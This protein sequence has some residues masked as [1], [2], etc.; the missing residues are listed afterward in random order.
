VGAQ[1]GAGGEMKLQWPIQRSPR[2]KPPIDGVRLLVDI[3]NWMRTNPNASDSQILAELENAHRAIQWIE[4]AGGWNDDLWR[5][6]RDELEK[7]RTRT[8]P[9]KD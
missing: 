4:E 8:D 9:L 2:V 6:F 1:F 3:I 5:R 7:C